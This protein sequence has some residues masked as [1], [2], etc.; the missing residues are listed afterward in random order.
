MVARIEDAVLFGITSARQTEESDG[1]TARFFVFAD[2]RYTI[3]TW[4]APVN[5]AIAAVTLTS[6]NAR[7]ASSLIRALV[8][9]AI[10]VTTDTNGNFIATLGDESRAHPSSSTL[11]EIALVDA[12]L[13]TTEAH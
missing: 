10:V 1:S 2:G 9:S 3:F 8:R 4:A 12:L 11:A 5:D 7:D 6:E 13:A